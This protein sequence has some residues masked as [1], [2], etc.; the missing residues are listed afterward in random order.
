MECED[1]SD[2]QSCDLWKCAND[3]KQCTGGQCLP[4][5]YFCDGKSDCN[6]HSDELQCNSTCDGYQCSNSYCISSTLRCNGV[7]DCTGGEDEQ[8]CEC[9]SNDF[10]CNTGS[11]C[12]PKNQVCDNIAQCTDRSDEWQCVQLDGVQLFAKKES[13]IAMKVC[14]DNWTDIWSNFVCQSLGFTETKTTNFRTNE[15]STEN[16][17]GYLKLKDNSSL[18]S[19]KSLTGY[20]E[21]A[22]TSCETVEIKCSSKHLC[23]DFG[24]KDPLSMEMWPS[25][26]YLHNTKTHKSCTS[27]LVKRNWILSSYSCVH[28]IDESLLPEQWE[29]ISSKSRVANEQNLTKRSVSRIISHPGIKFEKFRYFNDSVLVELSVPY[30]LSDE[31]NTICLPE[32]V[33]DNKQPCV[34]AGWSYESPGVFK[35]FSRYLSEPLMQTDLCNSTEHFNGFLTEQEICVASGEMEASNMEIGSPLMCLAENGLWQLQGMLSYRGGYGRSSKPSLYNAI[36]ESV[37]W[38]ENTIAFGV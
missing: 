17:V 10:K 33:V 7:N 31:V 32:Q 13:E 15:N 4:V 38:V 28:S 26:V 25:V 16:F 29:A 21:P 5:S 18:N 34:S 14:S 24:G 9:S 22:S 20:L 2:E 35:Q 23:G 36:L 27:S 37:P 1:G 12:I 11:E 19:S 30:D 6:D 8:N 3:E